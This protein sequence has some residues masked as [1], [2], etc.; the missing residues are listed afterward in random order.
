MYLRILSAVVNDG[1]NPSYIIV[2]YGIPWMRGISRPLSHLIVTDKRSP[3]VM[4]L[5]GRL[6]WHFVKIL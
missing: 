4:A 6:R 2:A 3:S 5:K 1:V